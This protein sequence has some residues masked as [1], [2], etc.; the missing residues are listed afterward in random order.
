VH[1]T[2]ASCILMQTELSGLLGVLGLSLF[3]LVGLLRGPPLKMEDIFEG[4]PFKRPASVN[5]FSETNFFCS[6]P[7]S[8]LGGGQFVT[9]SVIKM[10]ASE[11][12]REFQE[13]CD[14]CDRL[15]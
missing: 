4:R 15:L 8:I 9:A 7:Q 12:P 11:Y 14:L 1:Q 3:S 2:L 6:P 5:V 10:I 13:T